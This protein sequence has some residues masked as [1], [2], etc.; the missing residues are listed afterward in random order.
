[1]S[2]VRCLHILQKHTGSRNPN[3]SYRNKVI[4]RSKEEAIANVTKFK[5]EIKGEEDW[6]RIAQEFSECRSA[7]QNGDLGMFSR[8]QMQKEFEDVAFNLEVGA[9]S[10]LTDTDSGIHIIWRVQ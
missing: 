7:A 4:T 5:D 10:G 6:N 8:G 3:D 1:M 2:E 9:I